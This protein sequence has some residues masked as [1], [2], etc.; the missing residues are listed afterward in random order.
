M[1]L[2]ALVLIL[3]VI[4][5]MDF[6]EISPSKFATL[7]ENIRFRIIRESGGGTVTTKHR[8]L[9]I[10]ERIIDAGTKPFLKSEIE[11]LLNVRRSM[12]IMYENNGDS[13]IYILLPVWNRISHNVPYQGILST[14]ID[15]DSV[16]LLLHRNKEATILN[17]EIVKDLLN[18]FDSNIIKD[19][20]HNINIVDI[21]LYDK[22]QANIIL[23][24]LRSMFI[25]LRERFKITSPNDAI[26]LARKYTQNAFNNIVNDFQGS[27]IFSL[28]MYLTSNAMLLDLD[29]DSLT[30]LFPFTKKLNDTEEIV[31]K[32]TELYEIISD[33]ISNMI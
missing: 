9:T 15:D 2:N 10:Q 25:I 11:Y 5:K 20:C 33:I 28:I 18:R 1:I 8:D 24:D 12:L 21:V 7:P 3:L 22:F 30:Y 23:T 19:T 13:R 29:I 27:R 32:C 16:R 26:K 6:Q 31:K 4:L 14:W 17:D